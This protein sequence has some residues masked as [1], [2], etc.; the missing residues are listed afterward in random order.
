VAQ[1]LPRLPARK[2]VSLLHRQLGKVGRHAP[3]VVTRDQNR[4]RPPPRYWLRMGGIILRQSKKKDLVGEPHSSLTER[5]REIALLVTRGLR[6]K[7]I[8]SE[9]QCSEGTVKVHLHNIFQ[10]LGIKSRWVLIARARVLVSP[11]NPSI[12]EA[13]AARPFLRVVK[14]VREHGCAPVPAGD[15]STTRRQESSRE[16]RHS[17]LILAS[18]I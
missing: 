5:E 1:R 7:A 16:P 14:D 3:R 6:N 17:G 10:K 9:S 13:H 12:A 8:A 11:D 18:R 4:C 2:P 15:R